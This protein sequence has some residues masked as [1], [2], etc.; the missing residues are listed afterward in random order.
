M[1]RNRRASFDYELLETFEAG[2]VLSGSE[3]KSLRQGGGSVAE[4]FARLEG[5]ELWLHGMNIPT[6]KDASYNNHEPLRRRKLLLKRR[7]LLEIAKGL[8]RR[9]LSVV[10]TKLYFKDGW[11]KLEIALGRGKK[12]FDK[13]ETEA[14]RDAERQIARA[15]RR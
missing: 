13:R 6:Y 15:L 5:G 14:K 10:P 11:A 12:R 3:I 9:G 7:E 8:E 4:A 1:L 2:I